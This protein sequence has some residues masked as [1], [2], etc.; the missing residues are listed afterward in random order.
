MEVDLTIFNNLTIKEGTRKKRGKRNKG[1]D[2]VGGP[3]D[4]LYNNIN[5]LT[6]KKDS[7]HH[8]L[9]IRKPDVIALC[10]TK[11]HANSNF[12]INDYKT[13]KSNLKA[14]KEGIIIAARKGTFNSCEMVFESECKRIAT[15]E[16]Q[17]PEDVVRVI[18]V[19]GPQEDEIPEDKDD[20]YHDLSAEVERY[21]AGDNR[22][23]LTGDLNARMGKESAESGNGKRLKELV[24]LYDLKVINFE[25]ETEGKWTRIQ[26]KDGKECKSQI[27][28]IITDSSTI[29]RVTKTIIDE[30]KM[31]TPYRTKKTGTNKSITFSDHC[32]I[33]TT[34]DIP[35]GRNTIRTKVDKMKQ[36]VLTDEGLLKFQ[37]ITKCDV[38]LGD[39]AEYPDPYEA[40]KKK[41][42]GI[43]HQCFTKRSVNLG[44]KVND[45]VEKEA[46]VIRKILRK[47]AKRGKLQREIVNKYRDQLI[48]NEAIKIEQVRARRIKETVQ[49]LTSNDKL[50]PNAFWK[51]RKSINKN[52]RLKLK[53]VYKSNG[54]ITTNIDEIK[55]EVGREFEHRLRNRDPEDGMEGYTEAT[56]LLVDQLL[57][58]TK[59]DSAPFGR[60]ELDDAVAKMKKGTSP[61]AFGMYAD[62]I[63]KAGDGVM[64][65]LLQ[66][67]NLIK[68]SCKIP[69]TWRQVLITMI[70]KN[71]GSHMDLEKY[72]GIFLTVIVSKIF[73]RMLQARMEKGLAKVSYLQAG[74][75]HGK[76]AADNLF[77]LRSAVDH[78]KYLNKPL[79]ITTYDFR[80]AFDSL[81]LQD[82]ILVLRRL[83]IDDHLLKLV[84]EMNRKAKVQVKTPYGLTEPV[85]I[86][87]IVKQG[88]ILGSP[89]CSATTAEY[90]EVNKGINIGTT[91]ISSLA[92]VDDIADLSDFFGDVIIS[93]DNALAFAR[94]KKL[95][96]APDKCF[97]MV[98]KQKGKKNPVPTLYVNGEEVG[99][100]SS[101]KYLGDVFNSKG[102]NDDLMEDRVKR[103]TAA[104]VSIN[105]FM[106]ETS[107]GPHTINV[108]LLLYNAIFLSSML[109]NSQAWSNITEKNVKQLSTL[110]LRFLKKMMGVRLATANAFVYL[111]LG[112]LPI[113][114]EIQTRQL[115]FLHHIVNLS[116]DDPVKKIWRN[117]TSLPD[118]RNWWSNVKQLMEK[119]SINLSETEIMAMSKDRF[120]KKVKEAVR[121]YAFSKLR[122]EC[123]AKKRT[124]N[125]NYDQFQVQGYLS[126][127][128]PDKAKIIFK[129]RS[130]T[131]SIKDH[132]KFQQSNNICRWCGATDETLNHVVECGSPKVKYNAQIAVDE[133]HEEKLKEVAERVGE[134]LSKVEI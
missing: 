75:R 99:V 54:T 27:D 91:T 108:H 129:C 18:V 14:G 67:L 40:W 64:A 121:Q 101:I 28:Y 1:G 34:I 38:G 51:M 126:K 63:A 113:E 17:Y 24:D 111:E 8:I 88:G 59:D 7:L 13:L 29:R 46:L 47:I 117:Q 80:Q 93:H 97:V 104:M 49:K 68:S 12:E 124:Q 90:C 122:D 41:I 102:N 25:A 78:S 45:S 16:I 103:G 114:Y 109:F 85:E 23:I 116:E 21:L 87:D 35:K 132:T 96:L 30:E 134:F 15:A 31:F 44:D 130:K 89:M 48:T 74:S 6:S 82:C 9:Q 33:N 43:M 32:A 66:V 42:N 5:G 81:W 123:K 120:K 53:A 58:S 2:K 131:L 26:M 3:V 70:Y 106:R 112:V 86:N 73:E 72:R 84:Y 36:W 62:V 76:S 127:L 77:L 71:K 50:S 95:Q 52:P 20:F 119:Y 22:L 92:F 57:Q 60:K 37:E 39:M 79:Y 19:H 65:P 133:L 98:I 125:L 10:E 110:Q 61:D 69:E 56:N 100:V 55:S 128:Y 11:L 118:H 4:I 94:K 83:G 115:S 107:V 105:G